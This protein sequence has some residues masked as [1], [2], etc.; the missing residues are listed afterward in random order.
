MSIDAGWNIQ[1]VTPLDVSAMS[2]SES[3]V[4]SSQD[5][6]RQMPPEHDEYMGGKQPP[7]GDVVELTSNFH[8]EA[9]SAFPLAAAGNPSDTNS[10]IIQ[11]VAY[12][13]ESNSID[14]LRDFMGA[15]Q[16]DQALNA[17]LTAQNFTEQSIGHIVNYTA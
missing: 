3:I 7:V 9:L 15:G 13:G 1:A 6:H 2:A 17:N 12:A 8:T 5:T 4:N 14:M 11:T 10:G 16:L